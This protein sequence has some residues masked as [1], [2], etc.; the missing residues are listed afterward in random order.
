MNMHTWK[1]QLTEQLLLEYVQD[2]RWGD[3]P[4]NWMDAIVHAE[5]IH[6]LVGQFNSLEMRVLIA[7]LTVPQIIPIEEEQILY[8]LKRRTRLA[9]QHILCSLFSLADVGVMQV[10]LDPWKGALWHMP[11]PIVHIWRKYFSM[12]KDG[13]NSE[14]LPFLESFTFVEHNKRVLGN[15]LFHLLL[16]LSN[17]DLSYTKKGDWSK[18]VV[19]KCQ[20]S[21]EE[22]QHAIGQLSLTFLGEEEKRALTFLLEL[23]TALGILEKGEAGVTISCEKLES[24]LLL[25][26][27]EREQLHKQW[28]CESFISF[29]QNESIIA[30]LSDLFHL[31]CDTWFQLQIDSGTEELL[32]WFSLLSSLGWIS[33]SFRESDQGLQIYVCI[34]QL[35]VESEYF[36]DI[37]D[38]AEIVV[39]PQCSYRQLWLLHQVAGCLTEQEM[40]I[41]RMNIA[42]VRHAKSLGYTSQNCLDWLAES[43]EG[44]LPPIVMQLILTVSD[45]QEERLVSR[46]GKLPLLAMNVQHKQQI[47]ELSAIEAGGQWLKTLQLLHL[48]IMNANER[49]QRHTPLSEHNVSSSWLHEFRTYHPSTSMKLVKYA[50]DHQLSLAIRHHTQECRI[51]P[52]RLIEKQQIWWIEGFS[53]EESDCYEAI[54]QLNDWDGIKLHFT[55]EK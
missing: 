5:N 8:K 13:W 25:H 24:W 29:C 45:T 6:K 33:Y 38:N 18:V 10:R 53:D 20:S 14:A 19:Q 27:Y 43:H 22:L 16:E 49:K 46:K 48:R 37:Q 39:L 1:R 44:D 42:T 34:R 4:R 52:E 7:L 50:I 47:V 12:D 17:L 41:Y 9:G 3:M 26:E 54:W 36:F 11:F 40:S 2:I 32:T 51:N 55:D 21:C 31:E 15:Q 35:E 23:A 28:F 30:I